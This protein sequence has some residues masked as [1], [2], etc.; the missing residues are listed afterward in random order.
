MGAR[1]RPGYY[2]SPPRLQPVACS[3]RRSCFTCPR[4]CLDAG[5]RCEHDRA[6]RASRGGLAHPEGKAPASRRRRSDTT[7]WR[8]RRH[9]SNEASRPERTAAP[10]VPTRAPSHTSGSPTSCSQAAVSAGRGSSRGSR[11]VAV[12]AGHGGAG[13]TIEVHSEHSAGDA[14][15]HPLR[16]CGTGHHQTTER[17]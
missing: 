13:A 12:P 8:R 15:D 16:A 9:R 1:F 10:A 6:G 14:H 4:G 3:V 7:G 17:R 2:L 5:E 11:G